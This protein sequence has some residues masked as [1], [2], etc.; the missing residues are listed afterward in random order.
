MA[1]EQ[2][3][4]RHNTAVDSKAYSDALHSLERAA[5]ALDAALR[6]ATRLAPPRVKGPTSERSGRTRAI[7]SREH[8]KIGG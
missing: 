1:Q 7:D 2:R 6:E 5:A 4:E 3:S 8:G